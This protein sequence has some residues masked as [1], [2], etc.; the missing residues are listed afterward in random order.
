MDI[1]A[2]ALVQVVHKAVCVLQ[3]LVRQALEEGVESRQ[4]HVHCLEVV[5][6]RKYDVTQ[7]HRWPVCFLQLEF[8]IL[9]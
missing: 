9:K 6:L 7:C 1:P 2:P 5:G 4:D 8:K 3:I